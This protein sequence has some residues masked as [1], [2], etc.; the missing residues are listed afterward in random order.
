ML[1]SHTLA[2][3]L[4][5][6]VLALALVLARESRAANPPIYSLQW[7]VSNL[8]TTT[9]Q[10]HDLAIDPS[11]HVLVTANAAVSTYDGSGNLLASFGSPG[12]GAGQFVGL[13]GL[14]LDAFGNI[15]TAEAPGGN[16]V[17]NRIQKFTA[18]GS[19]LLMFGTFGSGDGQFNQATDVAAKSDGSMYV[20]DDGN[21]RV[22]KFDAAGNYLA[23]WST[24]DGLAVGGVFAIATD[25]ANDVY[26]MDGGNS[27]IVE[28]GPGDTFLRSITIPQVFCL[29]MSVAANG[30]I[31]FTD[32]GS[33]V[34]YAYDQSGAPLY[35]FGACG[36]GNGQ[37]S[38]ADGVVED[39]GANVYVS[40]RRLH[41]IQ[42]FVRD[43]GTPTRPASWGRVKVLYR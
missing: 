12:P 26:I 34:V 42:K 16:G 13:W 25:A 23:Q 36:S 43:L 21:H 14:G 24:F 30:D 9:S 11:G 32:A 10:P 7:V 2:R 17:N 29:A 19:P 28:L 37:F 1:M 4:A 18:S 15:Y 38:S 8:P 5:P 3:L 22:Q 31:L 27:R 6:P 35:Q 40:D 20:A 41:R 33:C 39:P